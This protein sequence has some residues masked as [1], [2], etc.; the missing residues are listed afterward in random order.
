MESVCFPGRYFFD[1]ARVCLF[2]ECSTIQLYIAFMISSDILNIFSLAVVVVGFRSNIILRLSLKCELFQ[3][4]AVLQKSFW[5]SNRFL[6]FCDQDSLR[7]LSISFLDFSGLFQELQVYLV[8][9]SPPS[10]I[11]SLNFWYL[12]S[13]SLPFT[14]TL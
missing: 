1:S 2:V 10:F 6:L 3:V 7:F 9:L 8:L 12:S 13:F 14:L 11:I 5:Y 4:S